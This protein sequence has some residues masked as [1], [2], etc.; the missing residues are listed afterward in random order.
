M[1]IPSARARR[2][3]REAA[4]G[5]ASKPVEPEEAVGE[6]SVDIAD[7]S[8]PD[9]MAFVGTDKVLAAAVLEDEKEGKARKG[10]V[11]ELEALIADE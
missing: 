11:S 4:S 1:S 10:L 3:R 2:A 9:V 8:I 6:E 5:K 7:L